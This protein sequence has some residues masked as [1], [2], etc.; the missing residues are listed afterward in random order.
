[1]AAARGVRQ[2]MKSRKR[3]AT[4]YSRVFEASGCSTQEELAVFLGITQA[5]VAD[6]KRREVV[7]A[8]WLLKLLLVASVNPAWVLTGTGSKYLGPAGVDAGA[9]G[10]ATGPGV[11]SGHCGE[12]GPDGC[13]SDG[14]GVSG[15]ARM[16]QGVAVSRDSC[17]RG[18]PDPHRRGLDPRL[19]EFS[20][21]ELLT[22]LIRRSCACG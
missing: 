12:G 11:L 8:P 15:S 4:A 5:S 7:P 19:A 1:M 16:P 2:K 10:V 21:Q 20:V 17:V 6:A 18:C 22:E 13:G 14:S 9:G 3:P